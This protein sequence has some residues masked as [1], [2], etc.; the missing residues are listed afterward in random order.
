MLALTTTG[1]D[2]G[3]TKL[4]VAA[5]AMCVLCV[6]PPLLIKLNIKRESNLQIKVKL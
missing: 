6:L 1:S 3:N 5:L 4:V 2:G